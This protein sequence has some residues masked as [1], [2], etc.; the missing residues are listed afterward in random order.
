MKQYI[1]LLISIRKRII[2]S[3]KC[4]KNIALMWR[5]IEFLEN[6]L[7]Y[8]PN[9]SNIQLAN[10]FINNEEKLQNILPGLDSKCSKKLTESFK[11]YKI[12]SQNILTTIQPE[13]KVKI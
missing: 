2:A 11:N 1:L 9:M 5:E 13:I 12:I 6:H 7:N 8:Y 3:D 10:F 4:K